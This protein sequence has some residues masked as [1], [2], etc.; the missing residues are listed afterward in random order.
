MYFS[1][2]MLGTCFDGVHQPSASFLVTRI[3]RARHS[4][5][6]IS[7]KVVIIST[8]SFFVVLLG[9]Q[10]RRLCFS[11]MPYNHGTIG[12]IIIIIYH[13]LQLHSTST[14][15]VTWILVSEGALQ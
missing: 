15:I 13:Q 1:L 7:P 10:L 3:V 2:V 6:S 4:P 14:F 9:L 12:T 5:F 11:E 8:S